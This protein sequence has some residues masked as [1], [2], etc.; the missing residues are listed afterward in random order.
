M[1]AAEESGFQYLNL[2]A[3]G[4]SQTKFGKERSL[5]NKRRYPQDLPGLGRLLGIAGDL[6]G[7]WEVSYFILRFY[8][9]ADCSDSGWYSA[10]EE[11]EKTRARLHR[12]S[13][14]EQSLIP[15]GH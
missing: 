11:E 15:L 4:I 12:C 1:P 8:I 5:T 13:G 10:A 9:L 14:A 6:T 3:A 2:N 7:A